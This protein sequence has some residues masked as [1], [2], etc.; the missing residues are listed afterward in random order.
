MDTAWVWP[1]AETRRKL[2]RT[3]A[4][5]LAL[6]DRYPEYRYAASSAQHYAW[7]E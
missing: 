4:N 2:V 7:L 3:A 6:M 1:L 5:Q